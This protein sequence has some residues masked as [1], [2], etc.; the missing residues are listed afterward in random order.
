MNLLQQWMH[1]PPKLYG[2]IRS[3]TQP[4]LKAIHTSSLSSLAETRGGLGNAEM[5]AQCGS[6]SLPDPEGV[7]WAHSCLWHHGE[8]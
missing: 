7:S 3:C 4:C 8:A 1:T 2:L 6:F 5:I